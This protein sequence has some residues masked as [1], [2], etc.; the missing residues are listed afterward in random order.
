MRPQPAAFMSGSATCVTMN[1]PL[2][3]TS[4]IL[5]H[6]ASV[7]SSNGTKPVMPALLTR[8]VTGPN[9]PRS[10]AT[11]ASTCL[12]L[13]M[14][15]C[16]GMALPPE[17]DDLVGDLRSV[18]D[19]YV[20]HADRDAI[21]RETATDGRA[22][23][24]SCSRHQCDFRAHSAVLLDDIATSVVSSVAHRAPDVGP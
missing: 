1:G 18:I 3:L 12:R 16:S 23:P 5:S 19:R 24:R 8:M 15:A 20:E 14:S 2:R 17:D 9:A 4:I 10:F 11:A 6:C 7:S 21:A 22:D 13:V